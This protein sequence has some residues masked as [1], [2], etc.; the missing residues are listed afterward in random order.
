MLML[1][2]P[3]SNESNSVID[4]IEEFFLIAYTTEMCLKILGLGFVFNKN[5]KT[6]FG[7][8]YFSKLIYEMD[9]IC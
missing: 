3:T 9:G 4:G 5:C 2:D 1:D 7:I 8:T 6:N